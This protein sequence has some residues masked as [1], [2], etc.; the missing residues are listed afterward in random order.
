MRY[1]VYCILC[2]AL[3]E[4]CS[5]P[6][7]NPSIPADIDASGHADADAAADAAQPPVIELGAAAAK[8]AQLTGDFD[9]ER[10]VSTASLTG[11]RAGLWNT[12]LG[13]SFEH[14]GTTYFLFGDSIP[15]G[16]T[17]NANCGDAL[18]TSA[19]GTTLDVITGDD[20]LYVSP[21]VPG[22]DLGCYDVPLTGTSIDNMMYV[23]FSTDTMTRSV[24]ARATGAT[25][26]ERV[27]DLS[28]LHFVNVAAA[29]DGDDV[30]LF[31]S[32]KY[33]ASEVYLARVPAAAIEDRGAYRFFAGDWVADEA[34]AQ[35]IFGP[36][37]VGELS[38]QHVDALDAW[39]ALYNCDQPRGIQARIAR[40]PEGPW[41][42][43]VTVFDPWRDGG[44]CHFMHASY[45][46]MHCDDV[47]DP[48][49]DDDWGGEYGPYLVE[50]L[51]EQLGD[52]AAAL[53]FVMSTWNPYATVLM[54]T[55]LA[56][57]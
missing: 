3:A 47:Q 49:R 24:L 56:W 33:R 13:A 20:G 34:A 38:V 5:N 22:V 21:N 39:V 16:A 50:R 23:W 14:A 53:T 44:Y 31:G 11:T 41:S 1:T 57:H 6:S 42:D 12:D 4:G 51:T 52:H 30:V 9:R 46:V 19:D 55:E 25:T 29:R 48:N 8:L 2:A 43:A 40:A 37:C 32:G 54:R 26:F 45:Q 7:S 35:P 36:A 18:A 15:T 27:H 10:G 28:S 17:A